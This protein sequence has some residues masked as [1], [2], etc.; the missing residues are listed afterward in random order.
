M[1][2]IS[3]T[4]E[5]MGTKSDHKL[6]LQKIIRRSSYDAGSSRQVNDHKKRDKSPQTLNTVKN[7]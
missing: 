7:R 6:P 4:E 2:M 3:K 1:L 5:I